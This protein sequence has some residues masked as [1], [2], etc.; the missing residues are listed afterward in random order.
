MKEASA[1]MAKKIGDYMTSFEIYFKVL[2]D[3]L[4]IKPFRK[5]LYYMYQQQKPKKQESTQ[6]QQ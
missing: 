6:A 4:E 5:E 2:A 3:G 1:L